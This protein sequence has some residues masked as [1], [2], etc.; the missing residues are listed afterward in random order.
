VIPATLIKQLSDQVVGTGAECSVTAPFTGETLVTYRASSRADVVDAFARARAAQREWA[1]TPVSDRAQIFV[2]YHD[3][4]L[5]NGTLIDI[6]QAENGKSRYSAF[7]ETLDVAGLALYY[8]RNAPHILRDRRR[9]GAIPLA[10]R[11]YEIRHPKGVAVIISPFNY[12]LSL[13]VCDVT[14]ALLA[15]NGVVHKPDTQTAMTSLMARQLLIEAGLPRDLWQIVVG[16]PADIGQ[17]LID[18]ADHV[19]FTGS[20]AVG[21]LIAEA[22]ARRLIRCTL[23]LG[24]KNPMI[25]LED[26][27]LEKAA[28]GAARACF[29]SAGQLCL[30]IERLYV[31]HAVYDDFLDRLVRRAQELKLGKG[32]SYDYHIGSL[33]SQRQL[34]VVERHVE[35]AVSK[36]ANVEHGG[37]ARPDIGPYFYEPTILS[38]VTPDMDVYGDETFGPVVS[39]YSFATEAEAVVLANDTE[40]GLNASVWSRDVARARRLGQMIQA[41]T[42]NINEG[43]GSAYASNDAPMGG[44][45]SSGQGR[46]HGEQGLLE[47]CE[48]QTVA[49]QHVIG[50]DPVRGLTP[51]QNSHLLTLLFKTMRILRIK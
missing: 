35:D 39:V 41:G 17:T 31:A 1:R 4:I 28:E 47:Y 42:V 10:T 43:Y 38:G 48:L 8:G 49:S 25:V 11:A 29:S 24:G 2:R 13:G 6:V 9:K 3:M 33:T 26:A 7:E 14:P 30:S 12:P 44:M 18:H 45:K 50:F 23:E 5:N 36:G 19:C 27:N 20:T 40:F 16:D 46:R 51:K 32:L 37:R 21:H 15:G 22:A 34:D